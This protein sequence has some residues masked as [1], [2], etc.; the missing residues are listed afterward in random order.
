MDGWMDVWLNTRVVNFSPPVLS[1]APWRCCKRR[2]TKNASSRSVRARPDHNRRHRW[3]VVPGRTYLSMNSATSGAH[4][5]AA[6]HPHRLVGHAEVGGRPHCSAS[7]S[8]N[9]FGFTPPKPREPSR[10]PSTSISKDPNNRTPIKTAGP[11]PR[12]CPGLQHS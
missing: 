8:S 7:S 4:S 5:D 12:Q 10:R 1:H 3:A 6:N 9:C 2:A 11:T